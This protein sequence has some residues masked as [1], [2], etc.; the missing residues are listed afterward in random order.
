MAEKPMLRGSLRTDEP[1][2]RHCS[3]RAGGRAAR[4]YQPAD[5]E[6]LRDFLRATPRE[7]TLLWTGRGSNLLVR[8][9]G[10][11]G[12]VVCLAGILTAWR[13]L[14]ALTL[15]A[16]AGIACARV[17]RINADHGYTGSEF[18]A[19]IPGTLGGALAMNAGAFGG[20]TWDLVTRLETVDRGGELHSRCPS[21]YEVTYRSVVAPAEEWFIAAELRLIKD[22]QGGG[23]ERIRSLLARRQE[24]QPIGQASCGSVFRNPPG[25][26]AARLI[27]AAG[28]KGF[29]IGGA[30]VST[31]HANFI[32]N[33]S[34]ASAAAI[35]SLIHHVQE[36]VLARFGVQ[37]Q[38][39]VRIVGDGG[40]PIP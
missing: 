9:G 40:C 3:W 21:D 11:T 19:G 14:D 15:R 22:P 39:E 24:S 5:L 18:L 29:A 36:T 20:E 33:E 2:A 32:V 30:R 31:E 37:L 7:E 28:L 13:Y 8:D 6:D 4:W 12:T 16:E 26:H 34:E 10:F 27:E 1:M 17:A 38:P 25:D 23:R 35:E